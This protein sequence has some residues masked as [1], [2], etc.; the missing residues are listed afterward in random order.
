MNWY[1]KRLKEL[2]RAEPLYSVCGDD[3]AVC[4]RYIAK[5]EEEF[6]MLVRAFYQKETNL[7][8][9]QMNKLIKSDKLQVWKR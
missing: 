7:K 3:C 5:T 1:I 4:P 8:I 6:K 2:E 9:M